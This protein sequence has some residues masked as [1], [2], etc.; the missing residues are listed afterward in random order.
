M[1]VRCS[2][3]VALDG[4]TYAF[5]FYSPRKIKTFDQ[6]R[7]QLRPSPQLLSTSHRLFDT[8]HRVPQSPFLQTR[9]HY[10]N[11]QRTPQ[12]G[13]SIN[14]PFIPCFRYS[15]A[16]SFSSEIDRKQRNHL[17]NSLLTLSHDPNTSPL[18]SPSKSVLRS[19]RIG[20]LAAG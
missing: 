14:R 4:S 16:L 10:L 8:D 13:L 11:G 2:K 6:M 20:M 15:S 7:S 12:I 19:D 1:A 9:R 17:H 3:C 5:L 18:M